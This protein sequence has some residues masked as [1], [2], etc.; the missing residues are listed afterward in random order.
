[1]NIKTIENIIPKNYQN[2]L[3]NVLLG[4]QFPLF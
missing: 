3:E 4:N 1:M 2:H